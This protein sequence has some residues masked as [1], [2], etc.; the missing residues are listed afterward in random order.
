MEQFAEVVHLIATVCPLKIC[1]IRWRYYG[2]SDL[3]ITVTCCKNLEKLYNLQQ[4]HLE[5]LDEVTGI[6]QL[7]QSL[8]F[9]PQLTDATTGVA[10]TSTYQPSVH[11]H[12]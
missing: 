4:F 6:D 8:A 12:Q 10:T 7:I 9:L 11:G 5:S 2:K 1:V 3:T